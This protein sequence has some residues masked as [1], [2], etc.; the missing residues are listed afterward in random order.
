MFAAIAYS[1]STGTYGQASNFGSA[2]D[3]Q[4]AALTSCNQDDGTVVVWCKNAYCAFAKADDGTYRRCLG[5]RT[6][7]RRR[8]VACRLYA[9]PE[10]AGVRID[11]RRRPSGGVGIRAATSQPPRR[12]QPA[13]RQSRRNCD[14]ASRTVAH[15]IEAGRYLFTAY[16]R[17]G[18]G[19]GDRHIL[20]PG[21]RK[22]SQSPP[23]FG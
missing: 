13:R 9:G 5:R 6:G 12:R 14:F 7:R 18:R 2:E 4:A 3:A 20:L 11:Q 21:H 8:P 10:S 1:P 23:V 22:M 19:E 16:P 15:G 17:T